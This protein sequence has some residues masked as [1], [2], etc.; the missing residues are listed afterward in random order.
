MLYKEEHKF[1]N[2]KIYI[3]VCFLL[4]IEKNLIPVIQFVNFFIITF[5]YILEILRQAINF[6][7]FGRIYFGC[8]KAAQSL[9]SYS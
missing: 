4:I 5:R 9:I 7:G 8:N 2:N 1:F 6:E 3:H